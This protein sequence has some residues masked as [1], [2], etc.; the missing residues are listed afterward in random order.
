MLLAMSRRLLPE[1]RELE[2]TFVRSILVGITGHSMTLQFKLT[3][4]DSM[5]SKLAEA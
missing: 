4:S 1:M 5:N 3:F 2:A